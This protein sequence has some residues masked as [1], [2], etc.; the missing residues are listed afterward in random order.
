MSVEQRE[1]NQ[2]DRK[3][4]VPGELLPGQE[5][6]DAPCKSDLESDHSSWQ[7]EAEVTLELQTMEFKGAG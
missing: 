4:Q 7:P 6:L 1:K 3:G 2:K 5:A